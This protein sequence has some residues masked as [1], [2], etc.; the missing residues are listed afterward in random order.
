MAV[1]AAICSN[2]IRKKRRI[3]M[4]SQIAPAPLKKTVLIVDDHP[5]LREGLSRVI[6]QQPDLATCGAVG[7]ASAGLF[8]MVRER[9]DVMIVDLS[10]EEANGLDLIKDIHLQKPNLPIL[11]LSMHREELY[12]PRAIAAGARG[13]VMKSEP[14]DRILTALRQLL[15]GQLAV[16]A[17]VRKQL[18]DPPDQRQIPSPPA[19]AEQLSQRELEIYRGFGQGRST[20]QIA[21][22][23]RIAVSTVFAHRANIKRKLKLANATELVSAA[24]RYL[25]EDGPP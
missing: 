18:S 15:Q 25:A 22:K 16:S 24:T 3:R 23:L 14:V 8:A 13:Y 21:A 17:A 7:T 6:N 2:G 11:A 5:L 1:R 4:N 12:G 19:P 20:R 10:L 9:P